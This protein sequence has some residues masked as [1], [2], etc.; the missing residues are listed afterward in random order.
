M[1]FFKA[2]IYIFKFLSITEDHFKQA[3]SALAGQEQRF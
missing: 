1:L 3:F 2:N